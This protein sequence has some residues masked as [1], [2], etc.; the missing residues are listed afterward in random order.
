MSE[1]QPKLVWALPASLA[2]TG[3]IEFSFFSSGYLDVSVPRVASLY[4]CI[5]Y[6]VTGHYSS[7][8]FLFGDPCV[9]DCLRL[10]TAFRSLPRPSS[11]L[12]AWAFTACPS[13]L[14]LFLSSLAYALHLFA[15][16]L[17]FFCVFVRKTHRV[18]SSISEI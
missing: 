5:Q 8:V 14:N 4:L 6:R 13:L 10:G 16:K 12:S 9:T 17:N 2:A 15:R 3:G 1:P 18:S 7:G 11:A